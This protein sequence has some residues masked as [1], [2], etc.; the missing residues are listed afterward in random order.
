[1]FNLFCF[2]LLHT[3]SGRMLDIYTDMPCIF[4]NTAQDFPEYGKMLLNEETMKITEIATP[5]ANFSINENYQQ[6]SSYISNEYRSMSD[7]EP[8]LLDEELEDEY[9]LKMPLSKTSFNI[10]ENVPI[11]G[12]SNTVYNKHSGICIRPQLFPD[13][14]AHV[15]LFNRYINENY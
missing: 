5:T 13:A 6:S 9:N 3:K 10:Q 14:L 1:M 8:I 7:L 12:K 2:S 11:I 15:S 4:V